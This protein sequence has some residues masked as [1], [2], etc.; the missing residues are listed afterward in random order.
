MKKS[1]F[2]VLFLSG[3]LFS[4]N[5]GGNTSTT[6]SEDTSAAAGNTTGTTTAAPL[7]ENDR[8]FVMEA[9]SGGIME[10]EAG[11]LAEQNAS[12]ARVKAFGAMMVRDHSNAN[13]ELKSIASAKNITLPDTMTTKH[14]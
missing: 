12:N 9:A 8:T 13:N 7:S 5:D 11:R 2:S 14:K 1:T 10:V 4:C 3:M 6:T